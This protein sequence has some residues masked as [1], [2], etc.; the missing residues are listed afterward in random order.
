MFEDRIEAFG[1]LKKV[2]ESRVKA[3]D[4]R[5]EALRFTKCGLENSP[6]HEMPALIISAEVN[7]YQINN[8]NDSC[9]KNATKGIRFF[10]FDLEFLKA[11]I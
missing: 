4:T 1:M 11:L 3:F 2:R 5:D 7:G 6:E 8:S 10:L 9:D